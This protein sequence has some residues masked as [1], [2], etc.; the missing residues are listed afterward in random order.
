MQKRYSYCKFTIQEEKEIIKE[1]QEGKSLAVLGKKWDCQATTI[2]NILKAYNIKTRNLSEARRNFL[3]YSINENAFSDL[4]NQDTAYWLGVMYSDGYIS[5]HN[6]TNSFGLTVKESDKD[7][8]EKFKKFLEYSGNINYYT[9]K[10]SY[11][12]CLAG[13]LL[14]GNNKIVEDLIAAGIVEHKTLKI[15]KIPEVKYKDDFIRGYI[16]GDGSLRKKFPNLKIC[17]NKDFLLDIANYLDLPY[18]IF[19]DKSIYNLSYNLKESE[20]LEKRLYKDAKYYLDRKYN[21]AKRSFNS[22][23]TLKDVKENVLN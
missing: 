17:G 7:L 9:F 22:P 19:S 16:D 20:Y 21:I 10:S 6:Y 5:K 14:I 15:N 23:L 4:A 18:N 13:R 2:K 12:T 11:G 8:L 3:N 1:Y